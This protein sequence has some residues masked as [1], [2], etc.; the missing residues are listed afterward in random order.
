MFHHPV[1]VLLCIFDHAL[2]H[3]C[4]AVLEH[5]VDQPGE[6]VGGGGDRLRGPQPGLHPAAKRP[7]GTL[8]VVQGR[9]CHAQCGG[10]PVGTGRGPTAEDLAAG[11]ALMR[12]EAQP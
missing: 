10:R 7:E 2:T 8:A 4:R 9:G 6:L 1:A 5:G 12:T 3:V 11:D